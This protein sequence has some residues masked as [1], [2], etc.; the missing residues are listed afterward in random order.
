MRMT[1]IIIAIPIMLILSVTTIPSSPSS[2]SSFSFSPILSVYAQQSVDN[3][4]MTTANVNVDNN[5][6][7]IKFNTTNARVLGIAPEKESAKIAVT[8]EPTK[9]GKLTINLPRELIDYKIAGNKDGNFIVHI[10]GKQISSFNE[11]THAAG[12]NKTS[13]TL[14][15]NFGT[16]D[17]TI[18]IIGTQMAQAPFAVI[19]KQVQN[20][21]AAASAANK[22]KEVSSIG[23]K[24]TM[25][26]NV[27]NTS[28]PANAASILNKTGEVAKTFVNKTTGVLSNMTKNLL[29]GK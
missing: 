10:N 14:D 7:T 2:P 12:G 22:T 17:R 23:N 3:Q 27:T 19:K 16:G 11:N 13:R 5:T 8:I 1:L 25:A 28:Q 20:E 24:T 15:I 26:K 18:E 4:N 21:E 9:E 29:G 6:Y